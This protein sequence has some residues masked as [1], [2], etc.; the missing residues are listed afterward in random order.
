MYVLECGWGCEVV[1]VYVLGGCWDSLGHGGY[2]VVVWGNMYVCEC[3]GGVLG[4]RWGYFGVCWGCV[5]GVL[6]YGVCV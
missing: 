3:V 4:M 5:R 6:G 2:D 1:N